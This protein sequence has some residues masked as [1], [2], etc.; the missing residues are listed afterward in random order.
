MKELLRWTLAVAAAA[1]VVLVIQG[2][3]ET[4]APRRVPETR[5]PRVDEVSRDLDAILRRL[6][7]MEAALARPA[8]RP[9]PPPAAAPA[10]DGRLDR[11]ERQLAELLRR[12][13]APPLEEDPRFRGLSDLQLRGHAMALE[14][15]AEAIDAWNAYLG[16]DLG[17][18]DRARALNDLATVHRK[19]DDY[20]SAAAIWGEA[21]E[22]EGVRG[23]EAGQGYSHSR[24]WALSWSGD[25]EG[26]LAE[27]DVLL[28]DPKITEAVETSARMAAGSFAYQLGDRERARREL[29]TIIDRWSRSP[30]RVFRDRAAGAARLMADLGLE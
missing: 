6:A 14:P 23:T 1:G 10:D 17:P 4:P 15:G 5:D 12:P 3:R 19:L 9:E 25:R 7:A 26:A 2:S 24:A 29:Q 27:L 22:V 8:E 30:H 21:L 28:S 11:V 13:P 18:A 16:R 20:A